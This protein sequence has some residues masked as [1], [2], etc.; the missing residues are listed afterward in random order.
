MYFIY[1]MKLC[2][3]SHKKLKDFVIKYIN[4]RRILYIIQNTSF[5]TSFE[6]SPLYFA[7][8]SAVSL[9]IISS[10]FV[11]IT[12]AFTFE[13]GVEIS[14]SFPLELFFS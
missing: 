9:A 10:S 13:L 2:K 14:I 6:S 7:T 12:N 8:I 1:N 4:K 3:F 5:N 11:G